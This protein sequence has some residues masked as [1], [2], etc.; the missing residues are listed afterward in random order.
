V[1]WKGG[2][3]LIV[4]LN[5]RVTRGE[6]GTGE[7]E[8]SFVGASSVP[9]CQHVVTS[10]GPAGATKRG[11]VTVVT[12]GVHC[13]AVIYYWNFVLKEKSI[14]LTFCDML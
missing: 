11:R 14:P 7:M 10:C 12:L 6:G 3:V 4:A 5:A 9:S 8:R 2:V 13:V 1:K